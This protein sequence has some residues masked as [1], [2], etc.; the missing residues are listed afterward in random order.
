MTTQTICPL[1]NKQ[2]TPPD[3]QADDWHDKEFWMCDQKQDGCGFGI[4]ERELACDIPGHSEILKQKGQEYFDHLRVRM[5]DGLCAAE[6]LEKSACFCK[7]SGGKFLQALEGIKATDIK[8]AEQILSNM[9]LKTFPK[10]PKG[11][12]CRIQIVAK[13]KDIPGIIGQFT[14][15]PNPDKPE[16]RLNQEEICKILEA[17]IETGKD[18]ELCFAKIQLANPMDDF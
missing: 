6:L 11:K 12:K 5:A 9:R 17:T 3:K 16:L 14:A 15:Q 13:L 1:C 8:T 7:M 2:M 4:H 18:A 10:K